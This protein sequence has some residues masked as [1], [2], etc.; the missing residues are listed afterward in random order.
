M[1][2]LFVAV[3]IILFVAGVAFGQPAQPLPKLV[4]QAEAEAGTGTQLLSWTPQRIAQAAA[5]QAGAGA[6]EVSDAAFGAGWD[7]DT[8]HGPSKNA[9]YDVINPILTAVGVAA[10]ATLARRSEGRRSEG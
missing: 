4:T 9:A 10:A 1:K 7:N 8:T 2:K 6:T 5:A 3:A